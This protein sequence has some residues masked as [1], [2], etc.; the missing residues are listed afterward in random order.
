[1]LIRGQRL[2]EGGAYFKIRGIDRMKF[3]NFVILSKYQ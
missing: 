2:K 3:E 1:M